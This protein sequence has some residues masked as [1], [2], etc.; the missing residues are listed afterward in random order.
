MTR[1]NTVNR[2]QKLRQTFTEKG[3]DA[4]LI[5][6]A[7]NRYY[8]SGFDGSSGFL[9]IT[10]QEAILTTD[11]RYTEQAKGQATGYEIAQVTG[12][13]TDWLPGLAAELNRK[14]LGFESGH[15]TF[16]TYQRLS[17]ILDKGHP[18]LMLVPANGL[19]ESLRVTKE[20]EEIEFISQAVAVTDAA[21]EY[22]DHIIR[23]GITEKEM[24]WEIE[25]CLRGQGSEGVA[26][27]IIV[28]SGPNAALP[29]ARPE[30]RAIRTGEP[31]VIDMGAKL[32]GYR[33][34]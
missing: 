24:A 6:Q 31:V 4:I 14:R 29:H 11:F 23:P 21:F 1:L 5:S 15:I 25:K 17:Y 16:A 3:I 22:V 18:G 8:L 33:T 32:S 26:F 27:D 28:A 2:L 30:G 13:I 34:T 19:V 10:P 20:P 7:D 12:E 9:L